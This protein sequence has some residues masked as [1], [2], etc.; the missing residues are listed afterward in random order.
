MA[1]VGLWTGAEKLHNQACSRYADS[2]GNTEAPRGHSHEGFTQ[3]K[4]ERE[5]KGADVLREDGQ[6]PSRRSGTE[7]A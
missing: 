1:C 6:L 3:G 5:K 7:L 2:Q 4:A